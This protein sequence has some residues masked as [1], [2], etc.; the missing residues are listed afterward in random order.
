MTNTDWGIPATTS[1][2]LMG[3]G[4]SIGPWIGVATAATLV[5]EA[6]LAVVSL[7]IR[8]TIVIAMFY[9]SFGVTQKKFHSSGRSL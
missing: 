6:M 2:G 7:P 9:R 8:A 5:G 1:S 4:A 3:V